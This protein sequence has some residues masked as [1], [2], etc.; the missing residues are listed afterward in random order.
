MW[1]YENV[2][3]IQMSIAFVTAYNCVHWR[4]VLMKIR[5]A[6]FDIHTSQLTLHLCKSSTAPLLI[7]AVHGDLGKIV[8][9]CHI[10]WNVNN[11]ILYIS[12]RFSEQNS[13]LL[14]KRLSQSLKSKVCAIKIIHGIV[15]QV[16]VPGK[17]RWWVS[18]PFLGQ[19]CTFFC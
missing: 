1:I 7:Y 2:Y 4:L 10:S 13:L 16:G 5:S 6:C 11:P 8:S 19:D 12:L 14:T 15:N 3:I 18:R 17:Q 9:V